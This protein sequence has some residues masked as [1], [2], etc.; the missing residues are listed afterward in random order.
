MSYA[1]DL[2]CIEY[3]RQAYLLRNN[4]VVLLFF[5]LHTTALLGVSLYIHSYFV[6]YG[7][8]CSAVLFNRIVFCFC[9]TL[10]FLAMLLV[11][12]YSRL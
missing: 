3:S 12:S 10:L 5:F 4:F 2:G 8:M 7:T 1:K 6:E 9:C 11:D